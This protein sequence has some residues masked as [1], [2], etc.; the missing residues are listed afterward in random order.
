MKPQDEKQA[1]IIKDLAKTNQV[2]H[3]EGYFIFSFCSL[4]VASF[5][6]YFF[7]HMELPKTKMGEVA[8]AT[9]II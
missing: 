2:K 4:K 7:M 5:L 9:Q 6:C 8:E 1:N 3:L